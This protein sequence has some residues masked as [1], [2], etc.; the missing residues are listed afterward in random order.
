MPE[1][2]SSNLKTLIKNAGITQNYIA[3]QLDVSRETVSTWVNAKYI[4]HRNTLKRLAEFFNEKLGN[5]YR[6]TPERLV[7]VDLAA[8]RAELERLGMVEQGWKAPEVPIVNSG[9][10]AEPEAERPIYQGL[11]ELLNDEKAMALMSVTGEEVEK[12]KEIRF[13]AR[14]Y[15]PS[16][17]VFIDILFDMRKGKEG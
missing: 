17:A 9:K 1:F 13:L 16:K 2:F 7:N 5:K 14:G 3:E 11:Q 10:I 4:P 15:N 12:L 6:L 8:E